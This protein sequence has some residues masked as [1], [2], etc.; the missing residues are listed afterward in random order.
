MEC[1]E[2][3]AESDVCKWLNEYLEIEHTNLVSFGNNLENRFEFNSFMLISEASLSNLNMKLNKK[4]KM[5]N[6]RPNIVVKNCE[7]FFEV[8]KFFDSLIIINGL[9]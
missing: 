2:Y 7:A 8:I 5:L 6:F 9:I 4:V 1:Y 3:G